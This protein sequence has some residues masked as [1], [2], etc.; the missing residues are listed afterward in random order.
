[1]RLADLPAGV[2]AGWDIG[3]GLPANTSVVD[4]R[5]VLETAPLLEWEAVKH[6]LRRERTAQDWP[7][8]RLPDGHLKGRKVLLE[9]V[10]KALAHIDPGCRRQPWLAA[11][12]CLH[13]AFGTDGVA[14]AVA[15]SKRDNDK[16]RK[17]Q[18]GEVERLFAAWDEAPVPVPMTV[19]ALFWRAWRE[20]KAASN[21]EEGWWPD[22][23][24]EAE[25]ELA[26]FEATHRKFRKGDNIEIGVQTRSENASYEIEYLRE[27]TLRSA[28]MARKVPSLDSSKKGKVSV[29]TLWE[30]FKRL[31]TQRLVFR[32]GEQVEPTEFNMFQGLTIKPRKG[33][34]SYSLYR[35]LMGR[36]ERENQLPSE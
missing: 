12:G 35:E 32:P 20:S 5:A 1:M 30:N 27:E 4:L 9:A 7:P 6:A 2:P 19:R 36:I 22:Q 3:D 34:G 13:H 16:H 21:S 17:F 31:P 8:F 25:A 26:E 29:F 28:Y 33:A 11:L 24:A 14:A 18:P 10:E 15:W 23:E